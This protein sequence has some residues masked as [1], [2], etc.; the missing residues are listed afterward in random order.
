MAMQTLA[1]WIALE[2]C[3]TEEVYIAELSHKFWRLTLQ[4]RIIANLLSLLY[5]NNNMIDP[6]QVSNMVRP[7]S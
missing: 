4:A 6:E 7:G 3:W 5:V 2:A 1:L